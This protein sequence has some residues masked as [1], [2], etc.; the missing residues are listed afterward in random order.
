VKRTYETGVDMAKGKKGSEQSAKFTNPQPVKV[1]GD[2][3]RTIRA[4]CAIENTKDYIFLDAIFREKI[5]E[6]AAKNSIKIDEYWNAIH[7]FDDI[8]ELLQHK[9][10][11]AIIEKKQARE[12]AAEEAE[13]SEGESE[14][15]KKERKKKSPGN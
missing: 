10:V 7:R 12:K 1:K 3:W 9:E 15:K 2:L 14:A 8:M 5:E 11:I 6:I 4:M 13:K